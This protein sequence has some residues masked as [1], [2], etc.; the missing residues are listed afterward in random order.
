MWWLWRGWQRLR[1]GTGQARPGVSVIIAAHNEAANLPILLAALQ[2]QSYPKGLREVI[3][4]DDRSSD[5]T[6]A[7]L[8][9]WKMRLPLRSLRIDAV[10]GG[11]NP[12]KFALAAGIR[13]A[14]G[15]VVVTTDA[16]CIPPSSWLAS[17]A[18]AFAKE[19]SAVVGISPWYAEGKVWSGIIALE[20]MATIIVSLAGVGN[21][22]PA[23]AVG[24]NFAFRRELFERVGG[25]GGNLHLFSG[26]DDLLLQKIAALAN[27]RVVAVFDSA[28]HVPSRG[29]GNLWAFIRQKRRHISSSKA[30]PRTVQSAY[31]LY[32]LSNL[33]L[34]LSPIFLGLSG[35]GLL[36]LKFAVDGVTFYQAMSRCTM[37]I[38]WWAFFPWQ[39]LFVL[40]HTVIGPTAFIGRI[41]W[42][43]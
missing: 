39:V 9:A 29:A 10:P 37:P 41:R 5:G 43:S 23:L 6:T 1:P 31:G 2:K 26:D 21:G 18:G 20:S 33:V 34:W 36:L 17:V 38:I 15:E 19:V 25:Y 4:V 14:T 35:L 7:A 12:K 30:Y 27:F 40:M 11:V 28:S 32:H 8:E 16:D 24:R 42:K 13:Q 3:V 22:R